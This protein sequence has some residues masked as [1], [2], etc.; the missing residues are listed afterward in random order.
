[1]TVSG[2][3]SG[4]APKGETPAGS[5]ALQPPGGRGLPYISVIGAG[6]CDDE[7]YQLA[8]ESG[9]LLAL[10][11]AVVVCGGQ[12]GVMEA[13]A[14][15][16]KEAGGTTLGILP[17]HDKA[18]ANPYLDFTV[19]TGMG[20]GRNLIVAST[21]DAVLAVGGEYGTLSEIGL[22]LVLARPV[23]LLRS[24]QLARQG[25]TEPF[26]LAETPA[27]AVELVFR[28]LNLR[29]PPLRGAEPRLPD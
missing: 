9:R 4:Q 18:Q 22:A 25:T 7:T 11:G 19:T 5:P 6:A 8:R 3:G 29:R 27:E 20:H 26:Q 12:G 15:G 1:M 16:A 13:A 10:L 28:A 21:G 2:Q 24:W 23:I 14:R 17:G